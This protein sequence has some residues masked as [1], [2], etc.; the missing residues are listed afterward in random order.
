M[1]IKVYG[2]PVSS[3][4]QRVLLCLAEK[5]LEH[6]FVLLDMPNDQHKKEPLI[7]LVRSLAL[8]MGTPLIAEDP[9]KQA[10]IG[11]WLEVEAQKFD[12]AGQKISYEILIKA[13]KGLTPDEAIVEEMQG[14]LGKVLDVY[15][16]RLG[17]SKYLAGDDYSLADL[18][19]VPIINNLFKTKVKVVFEERQRGSAW[20]ADLLARP[21]WQKVLEGIKF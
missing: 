18:H 17:K 16:A 1:A 12:A 9:K 21:A 8:K 4:V 11:V 5:D 10:I 15:E 3:A 19:H 7:H 13:F 6:E 2:H 14:A 20:C